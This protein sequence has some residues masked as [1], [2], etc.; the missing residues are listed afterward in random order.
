MTSKAEVG[1]IQLQAKPEAASSHQKL[2]RGGEW[3]SCRLQGSVA[4]P[5]PGF[6]TCSLSNC[7]AIHCFRFKSLSLWHSV[8]IALE[9]KLIQAGISDDSVSQGVPSS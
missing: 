5:T 8:P 4:L 2:A 3:L 9:T 1:V 7:E 6:G